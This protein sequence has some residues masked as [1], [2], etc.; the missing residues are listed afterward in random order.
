MAIDYTQP[1]NG[2]VGKRMPLACFR[3]PYFD[4]TIYRFETGEHFYSEYAQG[5]FVRGLSVIEVVTT[6]VGLEDT[7]T[8]LE[9]FKQTG[10]L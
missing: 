10:K 8:K 3:G 2:I 9:R 1:Y 5:R 7:K 6:L 4:T